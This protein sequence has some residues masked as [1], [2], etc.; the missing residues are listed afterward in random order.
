M[1][2]WDGADMQDPKLLHLIELLDYIA[3]KV[4][5]SKTPANEVIPTFQAIEKDAVTI[6]REKTSSPFGKVRM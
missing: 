4:V 5:V 2:E 3:K 6:W 1:E